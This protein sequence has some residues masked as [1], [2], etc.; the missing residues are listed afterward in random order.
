MNKQQLETWRKDP[1]LFVTETFDW[2]T[3]YGPSLQQIEALKKFPDTKRMTIR[4]GYGCG[5]DALAI[6]LSLW[7]VATRYFAKVIVIAPTDNLLHDIVSPELL[8]WF[9]RSMLQPEFIYQENILFHRDSPREWYIKLV[10]SNENGQ[11]E[12]LAGYCA[13]H[14]LIIANEAGAIPDIVFA[15][16]DGVLTEFDSKV[17]LLGNMLRKKGFFYNTHFNKELNGWH[18]LHWDSRKSSLVSKDFI[19]SVINRFGIDSNIFRTR[20]VGDPPE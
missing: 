3:S 20:V 14:L 13:D 4:S 8:K 6:W 11:A 17:L 18:K 15:P 5:K 19:E 9:R 12:L 16:L 2:S 7:F 1:L 10:S